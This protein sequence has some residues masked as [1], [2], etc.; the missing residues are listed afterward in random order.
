MRVWKGWD[1]ETH[2]QLA[3]QI[4]WGRVLGEGQDGSAGMDLRERA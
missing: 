1:L 4:G 3:F 2:M